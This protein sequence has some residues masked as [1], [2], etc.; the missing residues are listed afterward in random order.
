MHFVLAT[1]TS[2][3]RFETLRSRFDDG[4]RTTVHV[5]RFRS[6]EI[7]ARIA[8][9]QPHEPLVDWCSREGVADAMVGGFFIRAE[10]VALGELRIAGGTCRHV[11]F[12]EPWNLRRSCVHIE[13]GGVAL[14]PRD[15][16]PT[17]PEGDL[18]QAGPMLVEGGRTLIRDGEDPEGFSAGSHQFD[19]DI[20]AGRYPRAAFGLDGDHAVAVVCD[21]RGPHDAGLTLRELAETMLQ[22]GVQRAINLDGGGSAT[23]V[24]G[25][26][27]RNRPREQHGVE[28]AGGRAVSTA[29]V[30]EPR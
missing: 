4:T 23:L 13:D 17:H 5:A 21:G 15:A 24:C 11:P 16:L 1:P 20:T 22:L 30:F 6:S 14:A 28:I 25:G 10:G 29:L 12:A 19:S 27:L 7:R 3:A 18:L 9:V 2:L 26:S 8:Q